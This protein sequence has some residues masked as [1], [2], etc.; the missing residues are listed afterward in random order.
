V[1]RGLDHADFMRLVALFHEEINGLIERT[2][3]GVHLDS[4]DVARIT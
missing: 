3:S 2:L 1:P 4:D